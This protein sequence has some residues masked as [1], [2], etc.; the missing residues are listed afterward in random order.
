VTHHVDDGKQR[1]VLVFGG[2]KIAAQARPPLVASDLLDG[3]NA[4]GASP[5]EQRSGSLAPN[6]AFNDRFAV[7]D[8]N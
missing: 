1:G 5:F 4:G 8:T 3:A 7:I 2:S 6:R